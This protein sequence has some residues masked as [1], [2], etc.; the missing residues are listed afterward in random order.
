MSIEVAGAS[1]PRAGHQNEDAWGPL[2]GPALGATVLDGAGEAARTA[3]H[4]LQ[5]AFRRA[6]LGSILAQGWW[7]R[8]AHQVDLGLSSESTV[9]ACAIVGG[10]LFGVS[11]GDSKVVVVEEAGAHLLTEKETP[12]LGSGRIEPEVLQERV[13]KGSIVVLMSDGTWNPLEV[14][15][16]ERVVRAHLLRPVAEIAE[17]LLAEASKRSG[18]SL[19]DDATVV[20]LRV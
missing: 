2:Q 6:T 14:S 12:R 13:S 10:Q 15:A 5:L 9:V 20:V 8:A 17:A 18:G 11:C 1:R 19:V 3:L 7:S 16:V 4:S